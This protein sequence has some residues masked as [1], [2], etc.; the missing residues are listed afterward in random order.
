MDLQGFSQ[1]K[2]LISSHLSHYQD[3]KEQIDYNYPFKEKDTHYQIASKMS[4][5]YEQTIIS[6]KNL[7]DLDVFVKVVS[8][9]EKANHIVMFPSAGNIN[10]AKNFQFHMKGIGKQVEVEVIPYLQY[11]SAIPLKKR[12]CCY[13]Y[14]LRKQD[15]RHGRYY[16][17]TKK[18]RCLHCLNFF[19][20]S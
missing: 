10:V 6:T 17:R 19:Y 14:F 12:R 20:S 15:N 1:L 13:C 9:L 8:A 2:L 5:L 11:M 3:E 16:Q 18:A 4:T 7:I